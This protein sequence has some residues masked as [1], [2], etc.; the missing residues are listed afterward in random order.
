MEGA[1]ADAPMAMERV[2]AIV[3]FILYVREKIF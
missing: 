1:K 2:R 3:S